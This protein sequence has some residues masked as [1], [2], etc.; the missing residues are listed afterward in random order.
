MQALA[1][2]VI[3]AHGTARVLVILAAGAVGA[4]AMPPVGFW[5]ALALSLSVAVWIVDGCA[6]GDRFRRL[7]A[8]RR[9]AFAG[10]LWGFGYFVGGLWWIG[11]AFLVE[12]DVFAWLMPFGILGLPAILALFPA[13]GF[14][15]ARALWSPGPA[16]ILAL[17]LGL[18]ASEWL[19]GHLFTGFPWNALGMALGQGAWLMQSASVFGQHGLTLLAVAILAAPATLGTGATPRGR[20]AVPALALL[21]VASLAGLGA[22]RLAGAE[23]AFVPGVNIRMMQPNLDQAAKFGGEEGGAIL[24]RYL[25]LSAR[26]ASP[27]RPGLEGITHLVWPESAFPF[28]LH[29]EPVALSR[30]ADALPAGAVLITGAARSERSTDGG[31][32]YY[33]SIQVVGSDGGIAASY[34]KVHLVPFGEYVPAFLD[35]GL[36]ALGLRQFVTIPGGFTPG[37]H[38]GSLAVPGVG[39]VA[40][41]VCYEAI[42]PDEIMP[43]GSA[44]PAAIVNVTNDGWFGATAGPHQHFAQARL[45][46]VERGLPLVR[47]ANTGISAIVDPY[48]RVSALL[49]LGQE[50]S[51]DGRLPVALSGTIFDRAGNSIFLAM[52]FICLAVAV[53]GRR[54]QPPARA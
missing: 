53:R 34:D 12:A 22:L 18:A 45:R 15:I 4:L 37:D 44:R 9:A 3:L 21:G 28:L 16:R 25:D 6:A 19:R 1:H 49:S 8:I 11:A 43:A 51:A 26:G 54:L 42:F 33:N 24:Q 47:A 5:P 40:A 48:G 38:R 46:A 31:I 14:G 52:C 7:A 13:L 2:R 35:S 30:I 39:P 36:R 27:E 17:A 10:W 50:G 41:S 32:R 29:R 23:Q 20:W